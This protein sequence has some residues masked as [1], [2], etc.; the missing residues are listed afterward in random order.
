MLT[1]ISK[2]TI[3]NKRVARIR[4]KV[5]GSESRPRLSVFRSNTALTVQIID[6]VAKK[7]QFTFRGKGKNSIA[8]KIIGEKVVEFAKVHRIKTLV[9]DRGGYKYHGVIKTIADSIRQGGIT[10]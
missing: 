6:D 3:H 7:T 2:K 10:I 1:R 9:F 5:R 4:A 8:A